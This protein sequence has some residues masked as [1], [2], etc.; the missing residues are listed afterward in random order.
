MDPA[1]TSACVVVYVAVHVSEK[2][3]ASEALGQLT[4]LKP[5]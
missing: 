4:A 2:P 5:T 3:G 1:S